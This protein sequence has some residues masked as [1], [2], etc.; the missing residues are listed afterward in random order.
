M[1]DNKR[2]NCRGMY[3]D[4]KRMLEELKEWNKP[5]DKGYI[6]SVDYTVGELPYHGYEGK[7]LEREQAIAN[8]VIEAYDK[9]VEEL[10]N[11]IGE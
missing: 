6:Y 8:K 3:N 5:T 7:N 10:K 2:T 1:N 4:Y 11:A 9:F